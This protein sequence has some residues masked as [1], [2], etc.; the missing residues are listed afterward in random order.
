M[1]G[2]ATHMKAIAGAVFIGKH[3]VHILF[4]VEIFVGKYCNAIRRLTYFPISRLTQEPL[5]MQIRHSTLP[6]IELIP[7][8]FRLQF[9]IFTVHISHPPVETEPCAFFFHSFCHI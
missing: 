4:P 6:F 2:K 9:Q 1:H 8:I 3:R 5:C 7:D